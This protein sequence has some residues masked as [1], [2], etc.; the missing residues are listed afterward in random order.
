MNEWGVGYQP[1]SNGIVLFLSKSDRYASI[2]PKRQATQ[3]L[4]F[5]YRKLYIATGRGARDPLT[6]VELDRVIERMK[7]LLR[8]LLSVLVVPF[9]TDDLWSFTDPVIL[10]CRSGQNC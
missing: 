5:L 9:S 1:C 10:L 8:K 7:P 4:P 3:C 6:N 2:S